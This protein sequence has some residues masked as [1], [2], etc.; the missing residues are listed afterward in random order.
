MIILGF[1]FYF[2]FLCFI[3]C[4]ILQLMFCI[5]CISVSASVFL[6]IIKCP[7]W[8]KDKA[9]QQFSEQYKSSENGT[10]PV[11]LSTNPTP[12]KSTSYWSVYRMRGRIPDLI[13]ANNICCAITSNW[14]SK[15][16][17]LEGRGKM[18]INHYGEYIKYNN[19]YM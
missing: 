16:G 18:E 10:V 7:M 13:Q 12:W 8:L 2:L 14:G 3:L 1:L 6:H 15:G 17:Q 5:N 19:N 9:Q 11:A 4:F